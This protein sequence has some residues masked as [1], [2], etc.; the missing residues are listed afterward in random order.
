MVILYRANYVALLKVDN[1]CIQ[2]AIVD[3]NILHPP[4]G[5]AEYNYQMLN[6]EL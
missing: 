3:H 1:T 2:E 6:R 4:I 5:S